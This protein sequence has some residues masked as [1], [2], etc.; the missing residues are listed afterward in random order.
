MIG[1]GKVLEEGLDHGQGVLGG[2]IMGVE[3]EVLASRLTEFIPAPAFPAA[4]E[5]LLEISSLDTPTQ[6]LV[7]GI[8]HAYIEWSKA[9]T[10]QPNIVTRALALSRAGS[11]VPVLRASVESTAAVEVPT[12]NG[13]WTMKLVQVMILQMNF[14]VAESDNLLTQMA[15]C[16]PPA[17]CQFVRCHTGQESFSVGD[18]GV[19]LLWHFKMAEAA[20]NEFPRTCGGSMMG[21]G[22][23][24]GKGLG[25]AALV[26]ALHFPR[27]ENHVV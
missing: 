3:A 6:G 9:H 27:V 13:S 14:H 5:E 2:D 7:F 12:R 25:R 24:V 10:A 18:V 8:V 20:E 21:Q 16:R 4:R 15:L 1:G 23:E 26:T 19:A 11:C 22:R 17:I